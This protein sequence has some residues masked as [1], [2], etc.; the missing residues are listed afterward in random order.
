MNI[1]YEVQEFNL[2]GGWANNWSYDDKP[3]T[4]DSREAAQA[5]LEAFLIDCEEELEAGN[6]PDVPDREEFR[7]VEVQK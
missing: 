6:M 1:K 5:E 2:C 7:I 4:F 3:T